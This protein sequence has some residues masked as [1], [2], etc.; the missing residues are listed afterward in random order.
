MYMI[1]HIW[2]NREDICHP[3]RRAN[4][5]CV[6][7]SL[8]LTCVRVAIKLVRDAFPEDL[9]A[10]RNLGSCKEIA[11]TIALAVLLRNDIFAIVV[12]QAC[13]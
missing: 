9:E 5:E 3:W 7:F 13:E 2:R 12:W 8:T 11:E 10:V 1:S 4:G 6:W